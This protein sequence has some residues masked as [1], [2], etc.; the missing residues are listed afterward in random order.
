MSIQNNATTVRKMARKAP[1]NLS[2][3]Q[4]L[5][6]SVIPGSNLSQKSYKRRRFLHRGQLVLV[7]TRVVDIRITVRIGPLLLLPPLLLASSFLT[8]PVQKNYCNQTPKHLSANV[9]HLRRWILFPSPSESHS[10]KIMLSPL[11]LTAEGKAPQN[12]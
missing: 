9:R 2:N 5:L 10:T 1:G 8:R 12:H 6:R 7:N 11:V 3:S 4:Q